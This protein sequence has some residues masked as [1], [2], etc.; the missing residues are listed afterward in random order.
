MDWLQDIWMHIPSVMLCL[1]AGVQLQWQYIS[2]TRMSLVCNMHIKSLWNPECKYPEQRTF[3]IF[4]WINASTIK[5]V[6]EFQ[7]IFLQ[8]NKFKIYWYFSSRH[9][10][11]SSSPLNSVTLGSVT[12]WIFFHFEHYT[13]PCHDS[14]ILPFLDNLM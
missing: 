10:C 5:H 14:V 6:L 13:P 8:G 7:E 9:N 12:H 2:R 3:E 11:F 4:F 1:V